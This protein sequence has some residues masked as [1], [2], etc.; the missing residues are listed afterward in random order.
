MRKLSGFKSNDRTNLGVSWECPTCDAELSTLRGMRQHHTMVHGVTLPNRECKGCGAAFYDEK[1]QRKLCDGCKNQTGEL[2]PNWQDAKEIAR[3]RLCD[4]EFEYYPSDKFGI[5]CPD[6]VE[7]SGEFLGTPY[8]EMIDVEY[9]EVECEHCG[10][11][12]ELLTSSVAKGMGRFCSRQCLW[13][14]MSEER[15]GK[16]H[17]QW[18]GGYSPYVE[19]WWQIRRLALERDDHA[20][21]R[22][23]IT[24]DKLDHEPHVHHIKPIREFDDFR[25]AH[26]LDNVITLCPSCHSEVEF[27]DVTFDPNSNVE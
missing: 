1:G 17:H 14:W 9:E 19:N 4:S 27:G 8:Y 12:S 11:T 5:Y 2:N 10:A 3:C 21:Q 7:S 18:K 16:N 20:C 15:T 25:D 22:C 26:T 23:G 6:C 13:S 24:R